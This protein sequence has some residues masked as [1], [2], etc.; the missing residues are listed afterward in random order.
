MAIPEHLGSR[1]E[2][3]SRERLPASMNSLASHVYIKMQRTPGLRDE[4]PTTAVEIYVDLSPG[5]L[6]ESE[7]SYW[8]NALGCSDGLHIVANEHRSQLRNLRAA[9]DQLE[10]RLSSGA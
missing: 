10:K 2:P 3:L 7:R 1:F 5:D 9:L 4:F 6:A 8:Q